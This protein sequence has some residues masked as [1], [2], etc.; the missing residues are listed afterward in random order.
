MALGYF[1]KPHVDVSHEPQ[2]DGLGFDQGNITFND[3]RFF[4]P[5]YTSQQALGDSPTASAI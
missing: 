4:E 2:T 5:L 1:F 3:T